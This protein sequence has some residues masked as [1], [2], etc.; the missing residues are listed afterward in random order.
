MPSPDDSEKQRH[1]LHRIFTTER[2]TLI[3]MFGSLQ[4]N[5]LNNPILR[6]VFQKTRIL[7]KPISGIVSGYHELPYILVTPNE[8]NTAHTVEINGKVSVSP[9]FILSPEMM[10]ETF[11]QVFDPETFDRNIEGRVFA[12]AAGKQTNMKVVSDYLRITNLEVEAQEHAG[13]VLDRLLIEE[14]VKT[15]LVI[16]PAFQ[17][18]P[19]SVDKFIT[20][21]IEREF[22]L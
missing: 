15:A 22:G 13:R 8:E 4:N 12:F 17:Y 11:G 20:E 3:P 9:R 19:I 21:I 6:D 2:G 16:G 1:P 14:N 10:G 18:Y 7:R 5:Y